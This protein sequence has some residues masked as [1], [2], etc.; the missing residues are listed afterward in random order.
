LRGGQVPVTDLDSVE[1]WIVVDL[2]AVVEVYG[3]LY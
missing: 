2:I 3:L 1:P